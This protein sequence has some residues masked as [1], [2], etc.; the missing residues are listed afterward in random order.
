VECAKPQAATKFISHAGENVSPKSRKLAQLKAF[1]L[2]DYQL[3]IKL[4]SIMDNIFKYSITNTL[5]LNAIFP[6]E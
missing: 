1:S 6:L 3:I 5:L 2:K 4:M